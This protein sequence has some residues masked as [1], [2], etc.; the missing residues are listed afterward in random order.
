M[1]L[2]NLAKDPG[3]KTNLVNDEPEKVASLLKL[4]DEQV[5][6]G[7][8]TPGGNVNNDRHVTFLPPGVPM[9]ARD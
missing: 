1:Q 7:R 3:E 4:L 5:R 9:P 8:C 2:F 6:N